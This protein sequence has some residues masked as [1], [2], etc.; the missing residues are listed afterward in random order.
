MNVKSMTPG[1]V[2]RELNEPTPLL[3]TRCTDADGMPGVPRKMSRTI[4]REALWRIT[5]CEIAGHRDG[6]R[7]H[8]ATPGAYLQP[9]TENW[10]FDLRNRATPKAGRRASYMACLAL[11]VAGVTAWLMLSRAAGA[12]PQLHVSGN[13]LVSASGAD[14]VLHGVDRS[15][16][17]Y[18]CLQGGQIFAGPTNQASVTAMK[19]W[20]INAVRLPLNEACWNGQSRIRAASYQ[21]AIKAYVRLLNSNGMVVVLD[22]HWSEGAYSGP[23]STCSSAA[24]VCQKP[25]PDMAEAVPFWSSVATTFK[26]ND[27]VVFDL[28]NEPYPE[29]A[30]NDNETA[31]WQCW[32]HGGKD[33]VGISYA[34]AGMQT[35][36]NTVRATGA[37]NVLMVGGLAFSDDLTQWLKYMPVDPDHNLV[38]SWHSYSFSACDTRSCWTRE[39]APVI[40][41]VPVMA[42]EI[43]EIDCADDY[44]AP[45]LRWL[46]SRHTSYL[47]WAWNANFQCGGPSLI[48]GYNGTPTRYGA[49][50]MAHLRSLAR[51]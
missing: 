14:V 27:A 23:S 38:A 39:V 28:F 26:G 22:L 35:L 44:V 9:K 12:A 47:A 6:L 31:G 7:K 24:A 8:P 33:C 1:K 4:L 16:A 5:R 25:M 19:S 20:G 51:N 2:S 3:P 49:G 17:E 42:G 10:G 48:T 45:L 34:V 37:N 15:G 50:Y 36:V 29:R 41:K 21:S 18:E 32:L 30:D 11:G 13:E 43:G 46:D 40:A